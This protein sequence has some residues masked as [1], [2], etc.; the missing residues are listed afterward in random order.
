[1]LKVVLTTPKEVMF[2]GLA[3]SVYLP[4][5]Y[6]EFEVLTFHAQIMSVLKKGIVRIDD[7]FFNI[8]EGF[9]QMDQNN[10]LVILVET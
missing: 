8:K 4:G 2:E 7:R 10:E 1:M 6:G 3:E 9:A 5:D